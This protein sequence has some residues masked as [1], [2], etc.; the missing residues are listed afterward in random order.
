MNLRLALYLSAM[1]VIGQVQPA[2][3][4][5]VPRDLRTALL[6]I[7]EATKAKNCKAALA[8]VAE[9]TATTTFGQLNDRVR[10]AFYG[11]GMG[12]AVEEK[13]L[14][15]ALGYAQTASGIPGASA[16]FW[17]ARAALAWQL[18]RHD[19]AVAA[20]EGMAK[21]NP[22]ALAGTSIRMLYQMDV[23][24]K[25]EPP[26]RRRL[27]AVLA[28]PAYVPDEVGWSA[29]PFREEY[30]TVLAD[31][32][33][34]AGAAA[35]VA[36]IEDPYSRVQISLD[37]RLREMI[38][39][40]FDARAAVESHMA[41]MREIAA[42]HSGAIRPQLNVAN[43]LLALDNAR[44][45][46]A[47]LD[48]IDPAKSGD[49]AFTDRDNELNW[50]W[51]SKAAAYAR[52]GRYDE[53]VAAF[54]AGKALTEVGQPNISQTINLSELQIRFGHAVDALATLAP[55]SAGQVR[56]SP[57]GLMQF[58]KNSGCASYKLGKLDDAKTE[59]AY[60]HA[61]VDDAPFALTELQLCMSDI[62]G[63]AASV[64]KQLDTADQ[65][66][67][68]LMALSDFAPSNS[69]LPPKPYELGLPALKARADVQA[70]I[71]RAGGIRSFNIPR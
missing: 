55:I 54:S 57:Y 62:E 58:H 49:G 5:V 60:L 26:V 67:K 28:S 23:A 9:Q 20:V 46:L 37:P 3:A 27:L 53:A 33:D 43:D 68:A 6:A 30:A 71:A 38:P 11:V 13:Q 2:S 34:K 50:W 15:L 63:A 7:A 19:D 70:A 32:G 44:E 35:M 12:C 36:L 10:L 66:V 48:A 65:R 24:L 4:A 16:E 56:G 21:N 8:I 42:A 39:A 40:N 29:D 18:K 31:A 1:I 59:L 69:S 25:S 45:A 22:D 17:R 14:E 47:T 41:K 51:N 64:I 61:H 52:L